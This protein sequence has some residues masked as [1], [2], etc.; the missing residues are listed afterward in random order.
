MELRLKSIVNTL[1]L[2]TRVG[3]TD[4]QQRVEER[5]YRLQATA[6]MSD[7]K[8]GLFIAVCGAIGLEHATSIAW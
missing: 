4:H 3:L 1:S 8:V 6:I 7:C 2:E 5:V